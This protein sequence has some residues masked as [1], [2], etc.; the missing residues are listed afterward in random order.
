[1]S[2][3]SVTGKCAKKEFLCFECFSSFYDEKKHKLVP[4]DDAC[5]MFGMSRRKLAG[6]T[7]VMAKERKERLSGGNLAG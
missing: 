1:M 5:R 3:A 6:I 2:F 7:K 4:T